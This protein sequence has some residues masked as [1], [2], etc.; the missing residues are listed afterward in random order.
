MTR[1]TATAM[2][3]D[4]PEGKPTPEE[5]PKPAPKRRRKPKADAEKPKDEGAGPLADQAASE[6][7]AGEGTGK[8]AEKTSMIST[9]RILHFIQRRNARAAIM[10]LQ[11]GSVQKSQLRQLFRAAVPLNNLHLLK[12]IVRSYG[13]TDRACLEALARPDLVPYVMR[14]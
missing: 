8:G 5:K 6:G 13:A 12:A 3:E 4:K 11:E 9:Q 7:V 2:G 14:A 1:S 10:L